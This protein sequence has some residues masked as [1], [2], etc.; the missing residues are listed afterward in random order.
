MIDAPLKKP[1]D[2]HQRDRHTHDALLERDGPLAALR[3]QWDA[4]RAGGGRLVFV[5]GEAGI[6]KTALLRAFADALRDEACVVHGACDALNTP[7]PLG[8]LEDIA[9][10]TGG[11]LRTMLEDGGDR[12]RI[13]AA[14]VDLLAAR[15]T[16]VVLEDLHWADEATLDLLR[17][18]GRRVERTSSLLVASFRSDELV[19]MHPLRTVLG[20]RATSGALRVV[21][22]PLSLDA[23]RTLCAGVAVGPTELHRRTGGNPFF[24]TEVLAAG[25]QGVPAT[26][27]DAVLARAARLSLSARAVLAAAAVLG[28]RVERSLLEEVVAA[29]RAAIDE[30]LATG[31][32]RADAGNYTFRHELARDAVLQ[33]LTPTRA[34]GLHRI[35]LQ[36]L[37]SRVSQLASDDP[38]ARRLAPRLAFH[39]DGAGDS[40]AVRRWA[41]IAAREAA[42]RGANRQAAMQ[43]RIAVR[44]TDDAAGL[45]ALLDAEADALRATGLVSQAIDVKREA[46][47]HWRELGN[48]AAAVE[49][50]SSLTRMFL[51]A[52]R[53]A[54][55]QAAAHEAQAL[56]ADSGAVVFR[57]ARLAAAHVSLH[58]GDHATAVVLARPMLAEAERLGDR[59]STLA[60]LN[61]MGLALIGC[62][63][64]DEGVRD[65]ERGLALAES[66]RDQLQ[67]ALLF[68]SLGR[69][70]VTALRLD[71]ADATLQRGI[72]F[73]DERD[74]DAPRLHQTAS[75]AWV[76]LLQGRWDEC[77]A[78]AEE[79]IGHP[80]ATVIARVGAGSAARAP[81]GPWRLG[82]LRCGTP[83][84]G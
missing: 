83:W 34:A 74:L 64:V 10:Q 23:V 15:P 32:I 63:R 30:G 40:E 61:T 36:A 68:A 49:S 24:V 50:L 75:L 29:E 46:Q 55:A 66:L 77:A 1:Q 38:G 16:L 27:Q 54:E 12:H 39:A 28:P 82:G 69:G 53:H 47:R 48:T 3:A 79:V 33:A 8:A 6:G 7:R 13:F 37:A 42:A 65:L 2:R 71:C 57:T 26:V 22:A 58:A 44:H 51:L 60:A 14:F 20:D 17:F 9:R 45:A 41:P 11:M 19:P 43:W 21:P 81:G 56:A 18:A 25:P 52:S 76:R 84:F 80:N 70:L 62:G 4:S 31:V 35:A 73:C 78:R 67:V 59:L 5:E 72:A